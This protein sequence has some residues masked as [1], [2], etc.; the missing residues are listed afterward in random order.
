MAGTEAPGHP[1]RPTLKTGA[2]APLSP[3]LVVVAIHE[4][5]HCIVSQALG[6]GVSRVWIRPDGSGTFR[7][8]RSGLPED[9][10]AVSLAGGLAEGLTGLQPCLSASDLSG[11]SRYTLPEPELRELIDAAAEEAAALLR[12]RWADVLALAARLIIRV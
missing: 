5:G 3:Q 6:L 2:P 12:E 10:I 9:E 4:A 7:Q 11:V 8:A 1:P